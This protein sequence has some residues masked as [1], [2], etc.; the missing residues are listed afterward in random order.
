METDARSNFKAEYE[1]YATNLQGVFAAG[2]CRRGQSLVVWAITEGR[3]AAEK[4][5]KFLCHDEEGQARNDNNG[6]DGDE[7]QGIYGGQKGGRRFLQ[8]AR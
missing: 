8:G 4:I 1:E 3:Q 2:D 5:D 7:I 6:D